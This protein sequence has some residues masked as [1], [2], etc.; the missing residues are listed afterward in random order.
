MHRLLSI[1]DAIFIV[2]LSIVFSYVSWWMLFTT[3]K[4]KKVVRQEI[5]E[6]LEK[7]ETTTLTTLP[8]NAILPII[9]YFPFWS[10]T[11]GLIRLFVN[12]EK[13]RSLGSPLQQQ[14]I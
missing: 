5:V 9:A 4:A 7:T 12:L 3:Q 6:S 8:S 11:F 13:R 10:V 14:T 1:K 2:S